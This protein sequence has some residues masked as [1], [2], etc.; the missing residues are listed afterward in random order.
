MDIAHTLETVRARIRHAWAAPGSGRIPT[1]LLATLT[2]LAAACGGGDVNP[3]V[4]VEVDTVDGVAIVRNGTGLWR[5]SEKWRVV[6]EFRVGG[7]RWGDN[8]DEELLHSRT[9]TVALGP[10]GR[11]FVLEFSADRVMVFSGKGEFVR[12]FGGSGEGPGELSHPMAMAWDGSDRLWVAD[13]AGRYH[14]FDPRGAL[15][16]TV[17]RVARAVRRMQQPLVWEPAGTLVEEVAGDEAVLYLRVDTLGQLRD[18]VAVL[19]T[20][21]LSGGFSY[22]RLPPDLETARQVHARY[23]PRHV[24]SLAPD[25]TIWSARTGQLRLV[26]TGRSG[27]TIR[28]VETSHRRAEFDQVDRSTI[29]EGLREA[30]ISRGDV[31]LVRPVVQRIDVMDDGHILVGIIEQVGEISSTFDVFDPEGFFLGTIDLGLTIANSNLPALVGDTVVAV[32][33][34]ELDLPY[35]V[36]VTIERPDGVV[37]RR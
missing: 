17:R 23:T 27:D 11:I 4:A 7:S 35:L 37:R 28:I 12:S 22:R 8:P 9:N 26:R 14:V 18:T 3:R 5:E 33:A 2:A 31:E 32:T 10:D 30:G 21:D 13:F 19:P 29:A 16:K 1:Y 15:Q 6:E 20:P 34:G 24:W 36:R 25:G